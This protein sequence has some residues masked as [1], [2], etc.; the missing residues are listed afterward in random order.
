MSKVR[1]NNFTNKQGTGAP[2]FPYGANVTGVVTATSFVGD[3]SGLTGVASTDNIVTATPAQFLNN[4]YHTGIATFGAS[5][6]IGTVTVGFG[7]TALFVEGNARITGI[8]TIGNAS[9]TIDPSD[10]AISLSSDTIIRRDNSTGDVRFLDSSGNLKKIIANEV[11]VGVGTSVTFI[12]RDTSSG[13]IKFTD[14]SGNLKKIIA[15]EV[16]IGV[17]NSSSILR[18]RGSQLALVDSQG[19]ETI[20]SS[21]GGGGSS[22]QISEVADTANIA[23]TAGSE[24]LAPVWTAPVGHRQKTNK[25]VCIWFDGKASGSDTFV[26]ING[27]VITIDSSNG[28][29]TVGT[30]QRERYTTHTTTGNEARKAS[31][32]SVIRGNYWL[33]GGLLSL[34]FGLAYANSQGGGSISYKVN[35]STNTVS[36][37]NKS[38]GY[39]I[40]QEYYYQ[41]YA[42]RYFALKSTGTTYG[43]YF[44]HKYLHP[45]YGGNGSTVREWKVMKF[46]VDQNGDYSETQYEDITTE[47]ASYQSNTSLSYAVNIVPIWNSDTAIPGSSVTTALAAYTGAT[48]TPTTSISSGVSRNAGA[49]LWICDADGNV[50]KKSDY[51]WNTAYY[52]TPNGYSYYDSSNRAIYMNN[53]V[54]SHIN[55]G[56]GGNIYSVFTDYNTY[57][58]TDTPPT[59]AK[60]WDDVYRLSSLN[61]AKLG[62]IVGAGTS[63]VAHVS[64]TYPHGDSVFT[65]TT[66]HLFLKKNL[67]DHTFIALSREDPALQ[68]QYNIWGG[69]DE[70][71]GSYSTARSTWVWSSSS[72]TYPSHR[73]SI[74]RQGNGSTD[75][76]VVTV[77]AP[78]TS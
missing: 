33:N 7:T 6:G 3:G 47:V 37:A 31:F 50:S 15:N 66:S 43:L 18:G 11:R 13:D 53:Q 58:Q 27:C 62:Y 68:Q 46:G 23:N 36:F 29:I 73:L 30:V 2:T 14:A 44:K 71:S 78:F 64:D 57:S 40:G 74:Y 55:S 42:R 67:A 25:F 63:Y 72:A 34:S 45:N 20:I 77:V 70:D 41:T 69:S 48:I 54:S 28:Q 10:N 38:P 9:I 22:Y 21:G 49:N 17:G 76:R 39:Q 8:L 19:T 52:Y 65:S 61:P 56:S 4:I 59:G 35:T 1:A 60:S 5:N 24:W 51:N 75:I 32:A 12:G 16:K 26:Y